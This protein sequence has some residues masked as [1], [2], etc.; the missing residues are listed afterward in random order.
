MYML[1]TIKLYACYAVKLYKYKTKK[2][3]Q[4]GEHTP[5]VPVLDQPLR[6]LY[7]DIFGKI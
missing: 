3:F 7:I 1:T 6:F 5:G 4:T 2:I